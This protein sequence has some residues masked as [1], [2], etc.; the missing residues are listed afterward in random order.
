[1]KPRRGRAVTLNQVARTAGVSLAT[2]SRALNGGIASPRAIAAVNRAVA[3]LGFV[4][5]RAARTLA[6]QKTDA[7]ALVIP[8]DPAF[9]FYDPF[10]TRATHAI[11]AEFW[12]ANLQPLLL[13]MDP[14][15]PLTNVAHFLHSG[16][17]DGLV[18]ASFHDNPAM[19]H[20]LEETGLPVVFVGRAPS[21]ENFPWVDV[22]GVQG[23]YL[24]TKHMLEHG[25]RHI[26]MVGGPASMNATADRQAGFL[27]AHQEAGVEPG[28]ALTEVFDQAWGARA[29]TLLVERYPALD[30]VFA[31]SDPIAAGLLQGL[32]QAG[33]RVPDDVA[34]V[35]FDDFE[36]ATSVF[37]HLTTVRNPVAELSRAAAA[38]LIGYLEQGKWSDWPVILPAELVIRQSA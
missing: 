11:A 12:R 17:V 35:G 22:D 7:I 30:G 18:V 27:K 32:R 23:G 6:R 28:P 16:N 1:M 2:A 38:L 13:L 25:R 5:N 21:G 20:K 33:R 24:A 8:E 36:T 3:Q 37:P 19:E 29:A 31:Q 26:A 14:A 15:E 10:L 4:P 9:L 34:V